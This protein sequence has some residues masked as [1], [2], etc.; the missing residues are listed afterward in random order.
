MK[1]KILAIILATVMLFSISTIAFAADASVNSTDC[2]YDSLASARGNNPPAYNTTHSMPYHCKADISQYVYTN[3]CVVL[4]GTSLRILFDGDVNSDTPGT[5]KVQVF[6]YN[7]GTGQQVA[8]RTT[9]KSSSFNEDWKIT[10]LLKNNHYYVKVVLVDKTN[11]SSHSVR[12]TFNM[13]LK[14]A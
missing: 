11:T 12:V 10:G 4:S 9:S 6:V 14:N 1:K 7:A 3:Y 5:C 2:L 13:N 8:Q